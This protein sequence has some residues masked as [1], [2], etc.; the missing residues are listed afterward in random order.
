[1]NPGDIQKVAIEDWSVSA[2]VQAELSVWLNAP[3]HAVPII[4]ITSLNLFFF[5]RDILVLLFC[6]LVLLKEKN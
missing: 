6:F 5:C 1:M 4:I 3:F 2:V